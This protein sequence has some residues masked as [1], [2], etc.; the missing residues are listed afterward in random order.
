[1]HLYSVK[2]HTD[3][4]Y[5]DDFI[6]TGKRVGLCYVAIIRDF[7]I[8][9]DVKRRPFLF[10][11]ASTYR[12]NVKKELLPPDVILPMKRKSSINCLMSF[13]VAFMS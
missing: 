10:T 9:V 7:M 2:N 12:K 1:M 13:S 5:N 11:V 8:I 6:K 3:A 4:D